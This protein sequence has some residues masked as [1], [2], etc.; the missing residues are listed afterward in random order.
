ME[1]KDGGSAFPIA[2]DYDQHGQLLNPL[3]PGMSLRNWFVG[4]AV[5]G[6]IASIE[7][8]DKGHGDSGNQKA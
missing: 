1:K 7:E 4:Q 3:N 5:Q 8:R 6:L 2:A